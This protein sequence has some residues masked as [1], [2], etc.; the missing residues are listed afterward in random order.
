MR[1]YLS[2]KLLEQRIIMAFL[3]KT[4]VTLD[5]TSIKR[6]N[7]INS[8]IQSKPIECQKQIADFDQCGLFSVTYF[9]KRNLLDGTLHINEDWMGKH[10]IVSDFDVSD[11]QRNTAH[12]SVKNN[13]MILRH[14]SPRA[15]TDHISIPDEVASEYKS[16][17]DQIVEQASKHSQNQLIAQHFSEFTEEY[18][19]PYPKRVKDLFYFQT[20][21]QASHIVCNYPGSVH[22]Y[23]RYNFLDDIETVK[24]IHILGSKVLLRF[25][26]EHYLHLK[27]SGYKYKKFSA[28]FPS[29]GDFYYLTQAIKR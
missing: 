17:Y 6:Y 25:N 20:G 19:S 29:I 9:S 28:Q 16:K 12:I 15:I 5:S 14:N 8:L 27:I 11:T 21:I 13:N 1:S 2:G 3:N 7:A 4:N 22:F 26:D 10:G 24:P 18:I 23:E